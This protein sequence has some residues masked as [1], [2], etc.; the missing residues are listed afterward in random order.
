MV[1]CEAGSSR[2]AQ[3]ARY[4]ASMRRCPRWQEFIRQKSAR[5]E[6]ELKRQRPVSVGL[7]ELY[8]LVDPD[9]RLKVRITL[10][11][12]YHTRLLADVVAM[13]DLPVHARPR[14]C[15]RG[16]WCGSSSPRRGAGTC[17]LA[18][19]GERGATRKVTQH[20]ADEIGGSTG[21]TR[22]RR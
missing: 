4:T 14:R 12:H 16:P 22:V 3:L 11:E 8:S 1:G 5:F 21:T 9:D 6:R 19:A 2:L 20:E 10:Q 7:G 18:G 15:S 17:R 13:F